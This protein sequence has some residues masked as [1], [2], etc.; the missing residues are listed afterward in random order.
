MF[1]VGDQSTL[2]GYV[3]LDYAKDAECGRSATCFVFQ[4]GNSLIIWH[5]KRQPTVALSSTNTK[6]RVMSDL[7]RETVWFISLLKDLG[8]KKLNPVTTFCDNEGSIKLV[9]I[10]VF[11]FRTKHITMH[12]HFIREKVESG[13]IQVQ[14]LPT[15]EQTADLLTKPLGKQLFEK[16][17]RCSSY[18]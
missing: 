6:Y 17:K 13:E 1:R 15:T 14:H 2:T 10:P 7:A 11:H 5:L 9:Y 18:Y 12:Y 8:F 4:L 16:F 3:D